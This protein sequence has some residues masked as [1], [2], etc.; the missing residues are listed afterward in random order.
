VSGRGPRG[1]RAALLL[2]GALGLFG[3]LGLL[4]AGVGLY[5]VIAFNAAQ[6]TREI[7][8]R[9]ALGAGRGQVVWLVLREGFG[10]A[11]AGIG[12]GLVLAFGAGRVVAGQLT[13]VSGADPVSFAGTA[14][15]LCAVAVFACVLPARRASALSPLKALRRD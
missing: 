15:L 2:I 14:A 4:L 11:A 6:R 9:M 13:G 3:L 12:A 10:L 5:G 1:L 8:L 7:G